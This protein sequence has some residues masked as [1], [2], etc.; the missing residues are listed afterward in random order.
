MKPQFD[1]SAENTALVT[2]D[3]TEPANIRIR[4]MRISYFIWKICRMRMQ[5]RICRPNKIC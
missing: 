5:M 1:L 3:V 4:R 2:R